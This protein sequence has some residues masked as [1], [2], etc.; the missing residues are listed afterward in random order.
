MTKLIAKF[1]TSLQEGVFTLP[2]DAVNE[3]LYN[4]LCMTELWFV[5]VAHICM[6]CSNEFTDV[7]MGD[8]CCSDKCRDELL[9]DS[10]DVSDMSFE[11]IFEK[12]FHEDVKNMCSAP[13]ICTCSDGDVCHLCDDV[14]FW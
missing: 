1:K 3:D 11:V 8:A 9:R 7:T 13:A 14:P 10:E 12:S 6:V 4:S 5:P 2:V